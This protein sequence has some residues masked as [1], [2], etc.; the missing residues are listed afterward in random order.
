MSRL[1]VTGANGFAG[2]HLCALLRSL[3]HEVHATI[4]TVTADPERTNEADLGCA[5]VHAVDITDAVAVERVLGEVEP[6][7]V[8]HLAGQAFVPDSR[9]DPSRTFNVNTIGTVHVLAAVRNRCPAARVVCVGSAEVYGLVGESDLPITEACRMR[10]LSPYAASKAAAD[11]VAYQYAIGDGVD[12]VRVRPFN[13]TGA[14]QRR[15]FVCPD[16]ASQ[17]AEMESG[18]RAAR[19]RV[20]DLDVVRDLSD[21]RDVVAGY[22]AL[23]KKGRTGE[24]YNICSGVGRSIRDVLNDLIGMTDLEVEVEVDM[25]RVRKR[26]VPSVIGSAEKLRSETGWKPRHEWKDT[27]ASVLEDCR[28]RAQQA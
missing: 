19:M 2:R 8:F 5:A 11:L 13:H 1:L 10:P 22:V 27:L 28:K 9:R 6:D 17:L 20:G 25:A 16:F 14:G 24:V 12:V 23:W 4:R 26:R 15:S 18:G 21:V 3:E 7:A